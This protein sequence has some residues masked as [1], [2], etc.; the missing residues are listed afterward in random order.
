M[1]SM[2][3]YIIGISVVSAFIKSLGSYLY[4]QKHEIDVAYSH[5]V[6]DF[7]FTLIVVLVSLLLIHQIFKYKIKGLTSGNESFIEAINEPILSGI[8]NF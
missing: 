1:Y 7:V 8:A 6:V 5:Y 2:F 4:D 3:E